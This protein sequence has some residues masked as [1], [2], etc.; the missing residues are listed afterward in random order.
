MESS[1]LNLVYIKNVRGDYIPTRITHVRDEGRSQHISF[2]VKFDHIVDRSSADALKQSSIYLEHSH[3]EE[4]Q[5][6]EDEDPLVG[7]SVFDEE[8]QLIGIISEVLETAAHPII[9]V[10]KNKDSLMVPFVDEFILSVDDE[11]EA[12]VCHNLDQFEEE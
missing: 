1:S 5:V 8:Q 4:W 6:Q 11:S 2:F 9:V 12:I 3:S 10:Q 7:Y